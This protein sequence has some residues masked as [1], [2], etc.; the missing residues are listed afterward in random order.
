L[1]ELK[2][3]TRTASDGLCVT[4]ICKHPRPPENI[5]LNNVFIFSQ[6]QLLYLHKKDHS[7]QLQNK[8]AAQSNEEGAMNVQCNM[9]FC[10]QHHTFRVLSQNAK[11]PV[12]N[13]LQN[14]QMY[15]F[16]TLV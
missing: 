5:S 14:G 9:Q 16:W 8:D 13:A 7:L 12:D 2:S 6:K 11:I 4:C 3:S 1:A 15:C 10:K